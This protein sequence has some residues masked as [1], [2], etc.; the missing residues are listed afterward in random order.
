[1][2]FDC[3]PQLVLLDRGLF[4]LS[5]PLVWH[6]NG[7][8]IRLSVMVPAGYITD[9]ASVPKLFRW[10]VGASATRT[11]AA[12][13]H[14]VLYGP[15]RFD[16]VV[17]DALFRAIMLEEGVPRFTA[18]LMWL[19]VRLGGWWTYYIGASRTEYKETKHARKSP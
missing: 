11:K 15:A 9:L 18:H 6:H 12:I 10:L 13:V 14:D 17:A 16:R 5:Q 3:D 1:M 8:P 19:A 4:K 2:P 7:G